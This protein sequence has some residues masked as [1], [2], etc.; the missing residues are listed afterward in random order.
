M[1][2]GLAITVCSSLHFMLVQRI[3]SMGYELGF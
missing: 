2:A 1:K 3:N